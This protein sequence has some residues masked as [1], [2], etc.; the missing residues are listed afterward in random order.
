VS[1]NPHHPYEGQQVAVLGLGRSG[2]AAA[3]LLAQLG[4]KVT[5]LDSAEAARL[6]ASKLETLRDAGVQ[7]IF[8]AGAAQDTR[9]YEFAVL[10]PGI[11]P[12]TPLVQNFLARDI[13]LISEIELAYRHSSVPVIGITGTNGKTTTTELV[14]AMLT[15]AGVRTVAA[16]NI[17]IPYSEVVREAAPLDVLTLEVSSF[18]LER[19]E[20]F[21]PAVSVWLNL[22]PD[23]L[24]RYRDADE[25]RQAKLR[26]FEQQTAADWAVVN[27]RDSLPPL[28]AQR[29]TFSAYDDTADLRLRDEI[30][31]YG[32]EPILDPRE[33]RL[34]GRHNTE[35]LMAALG[36]GLARGLTPAQ[37]T[38]ALRDY[39][40][41]PHRYEL[42]RELGDVLYIN[43]SKATNLDA[44]E[45]ALTS[46]ARPVILIAGGKDKGFAFDP[47]AAVVA[48]KARWVILI[49]EMS[50][51]IAASWGENVPCELAASLSQAVT[52]A[53]SLARPGEV[54]LFSPGTSSFDMF[55]SYADRGNQFRALVH[56]LPNTSEFMD[57]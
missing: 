3:R 14:A 26:I 29:I 53:W 7:E 51:R 8:G 22:T 50:E 5:V 44:L 34:R 48:E 36:V 17:G 38:P 2:E 16:G 25:Y 47:L 40:P 33:T 45:K 20:T 23:H 1:T 56:A 10:S 49:G 55:T 27:A 19:I 54:V 32:A 24:D 11:D 30:I 43:D 4:A 52:M 6:D 9:S 57:S 37:M 31:H 41:Q 15:G 39:H 13:P 18:Q 35:N 12:A 46:E 42:V 21:R 28:A